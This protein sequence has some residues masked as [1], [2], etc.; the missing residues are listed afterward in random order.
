MPRL[1]GETMKMLERCQGDLNESPLT[2]PFKPGARPV[3]SEVED[4]VRHEFAL[5]DDAGGDQD[6]A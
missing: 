6:T 3:E 5:R 4:P 2:R 1:R